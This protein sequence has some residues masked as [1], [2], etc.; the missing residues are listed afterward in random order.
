MITL[1]NYVC[2]FLE[3][4]GDYLL[5]KRAADR[6]VNPNVWSGVGGK[7]EENELNDPFAACI[8]EIGEETGLQHVQIKNLTLRYIIL[9]RHKDVIRQSYIYFGQ[10]STRTYS[11]T[12]EGVLHWIPKT[13]LPE[14]RYTETYAAMI[15]HFLSDKSDPDHVVIGVAG[16]EDGILQMHWNRIE[17][18]LK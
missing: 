11:D 17:D 15:R 2:A 14:K 9:R 13:E 12:N 5:L 10:S 8:R 7:I 6:A 16:C 18:F 3:N 1:I 4:N